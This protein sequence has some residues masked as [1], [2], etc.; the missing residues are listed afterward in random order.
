MIFS[1]SN[2]VRCAQ[3]PL[4]C[5]PGRITEPVQGGKCPGLQPLDIL[6]CPLLRCLTWTPPLLWFQTPKPLPA[7]GSRPSTPSPFKHAHSPELVLPHSHCGRSGFQTQWDPVSLHKWSHAK[8]LHIGTVQAHTHMCSHTC[9]H[10]YT[11]AESHAWSC[12]D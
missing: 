8:P 10:V 9:T 4:L 7:C 11:G 12:Q 2:H 3:S 1:V 6:A 5:K